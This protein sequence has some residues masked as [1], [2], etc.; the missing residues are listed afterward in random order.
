MTTRTKR[1]E[2]SKIAIGVQ[3]LP[4]R[5]AFMR[6]EKYVAI[7]QREIEGRTNTFVELSSATARAL[8][9]ARDLATISSDAIVRLASE[10][11]FALAELKRQNETIKE[12]EAEVAL[13]K[14]NVEQMRRNIEDDANDPPFQRSPPSHLAKA[15]ERGTN[16]A[17]RP[18]QGGLAGATKK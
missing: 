11:A 10:K 6:H 12:L 17:T 8:F 18:L 15:L 13:H 3:L 9:K 5:M 16:F 14:R 2:R 7:V 4:A 1:L